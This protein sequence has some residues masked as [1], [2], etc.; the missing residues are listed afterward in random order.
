M[1]ESYS[2]QDDCRQ[3]R[4]RKIQANRSE[5]PFF[6]QIP[7]EKPIGTAKLRVC[8]ACYSSWIKTNFPKSKRTFPAYGKNRSRVK[9]SRV[10]SSLNIKIPLVIGTK[11]LRR[12]QGMLIDRS[13]RSASIITDRP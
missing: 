11:A 4:F 9:I 1:K 2:A 3:Q 7:Q 12:R 10:H 6:N 5:A 8:S 13:A